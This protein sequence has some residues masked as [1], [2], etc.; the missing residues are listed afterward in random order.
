MLFSAFLVKGKM[1][2]AGNQPLR[3]SS[4]PHSEI[5]PES[6]EAFLDETVP[7]NM[8]RSHVPGLV[9]TVVEG[10]EVLLSKGYGYADLENR[11]PMTPQT[12]VRA[13]S[14]SKTVLATAVIQLVAQGTLDLDAPVSEYISDLD[15]ADEYGPA[16]TVGQLLNHMG[17]YPD[18]VVLSHAP[19]LAHW[20]PLGDVLRADLPSRAFA[21][22]LVMAYSSWDY[23]LL[24]YAIEGVTGL[25]YEDAVAE[26]LFTP[27]G[28]ENST[29]AQPLPP[30]IYD[31]LAVG[32][33]YN[34]STTGYDIV[35]HDF[36]RMSPGVAL[37]TNGEDMGNY[38]R[39][40]LNGGSLDGNQIFE[41]EALAMLLERQASAHPFSRGRSYAFWEQTLA[42]RKVLY[43]DGN[44][45]G[46]SSTIVLMPQQDLGV[47]I[48]V[49]HR[50]LHRGLRPTE[51]SAMVRT[52]STEI[53]ENFVP[54]TEVEM[55]QV[56]PLPDRA[57]HIERFTGHYQFA[58]A[59]SRSDFFKLEAM[60]DNVNVRDNGDG[61]LRIGSGVYVEVEPLVFQSVKNLGFFVI[62]VENQVGEV[63]FLTFGGTGSYQKA[64]WYQSMNFQ[65]ILVGVIT[66]I[67][68]SML[69]AWP[70]KRQGHWM[71]WAVSL[72]NLGFIV[73]VGMLFIT[74]ITD[75]LLF[76]KT[77]PI[78]ARILFAMPWIIGILSLSL[79]VF[80]VLMWKDG[81]TSWWGRTHYLLVTLAS[82]AVFWLANFWN[83]IL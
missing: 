9:I 28:M 3:M 47:F 38:M 83:L 12:N 60:L 68:L 15:L 8:E 46:F 5:D 2:I 80:L 26:L 49:N 79:P 36:V 48:S 64:P 81:D 31:N 29:Y 18:A 44:G 40:L 72:L 11:I 56:R 21:P 35:P 30:E 61:S 43:H 17:G 55:P 78:G 65:I 63:E 53:L 23:A 39:A 20:D 66:L 22:G 54:E 27:L 45:I 19:D 50:S 13:G 6:L 77:I 7:E 1:A 82:F 67:S 71:A 24:G 57:D 59:I 25:P 41:D 62:F 16:S 74:Q 10:D 75:L 14:V 70:I 42:G 52:L 33:G 32:Y 51:A 34:Y 37:V 73:G 4:N 69:I 58:T 76:F